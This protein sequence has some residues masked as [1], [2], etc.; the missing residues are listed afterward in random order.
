MVVNR[1]HAIRRTAEGVLAGLGFGQLHFAEASEAKQLQITFDDGPEPVSDALT[2]ILEELARRGRVASFF[3]LGGEV[4]SS[5][6]ATRTIL[7]KGHVLGNHSWDHLMP[8]TV[9]YT[10][11]QVLDQFKR[12]H[13]EVLSVTKHAMKHWRAPRLEQIARLTGLLVGPGRLYS[14]SHCDVHADSKDSQGQTTSAGMLGAIRSDVKAQPNRRVYRVLFHVKA[15]T[16][17]ALPRILDGLVADG[18][19]LADFSQSS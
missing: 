12:T 7:G 8:S 11:A 9:R 19:V 6:E 17:R 14:L 2:P 10:D 3:N 1:R 16:A 15:T 5:P 13:E 4:H 18:H